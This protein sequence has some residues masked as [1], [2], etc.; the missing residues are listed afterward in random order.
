MQA[1]H[2]GTKGEGY[3]D[4]RSAITLWLYATTMIFVSLVSAFLALSYL[5]CPANVCPDPLHANDEEPVLMQA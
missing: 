4:R 2:R 5:I 3:H 1:S